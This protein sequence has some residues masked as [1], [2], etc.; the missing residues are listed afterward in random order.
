MQGSGWGWEKPHLRNIP[1]F[2]GRY[3]PVFFGT[4]LAGQ[5]PQKFNRKYILVQ[6]TPIFQAAMLVRGFFGWLGGRLAVLRSLLWPV[7][8]SMAGH[9]VWWAPRSKTFSPLRSLLIRRVQPGPAGLGG[10]LLFS[11]AMFW[12]DQKRR[13]SH[14]PKR[15]QH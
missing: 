3:T 10:L 9:E 5:I 11:A 1:R 13:Y 4:W 2:W 8:S 14:C 6:G 12:G 7:T 15:I